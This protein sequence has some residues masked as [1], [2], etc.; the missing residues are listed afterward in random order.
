MAIFKNGSL[1]SEIV[2]KLSGQI[3][4]RSK[5]APVIYSRTYAKSPHVGRQDIVRQRFSKLEQVWKT[6]PVSFQDSWSTQASQNDLINSVGQIYHESGLNLFCRLN[7]QRVNRGLPILLSPPGSKPDI[8]FINFFFDF[9]P[10]DDIFKLDILSSFPDDTYY[11]IEATSLLSPGIKYATDRL[12]QIA[13]LTSADVPSLNLNDAY[14]AVY[15]IGIEDMPSNAFMWLS[16]RA[17]SESTGYS[18]GRITFNGFQPFPFDPD[19]KNVVKRMEQVGT[20]L[21]LSEQ[22][23]I[24]TFVL[25]LKGL[26]SFGATDIWSQLDYLRFGS[27]NQANHAL[28]EWRMLSGFG[29]NDAIP[30]GAPLFSAGQ[31]FQG[32]TNDAIQE[33]FVPASPPGGLFSIDNCFIGALE[34][35]GALNEHTFGIDDTPNSIMLINGTFNDTGA[36]NSVSGN[37]SGIPFGPGWRS[38]RRFQPTH[39]DA[40]IDTTNVF[41]FP[42]SS[43][44]LSIFN[45]YSSGLNAAG[46]LSPSPNS[47]VGGFFAGADFSADINQ[48]ID[49]YNQFMVDFNA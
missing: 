33:S 22:M 1:V 4:S 30:I 3:Y 37:T 15:G 19:A 6:L 29:A 35:G 31:G 12:Q 36:L 14:K 40:F 13:L 32:G 8:N 21:S 26:G 48:F 23:A 47:I 49:S 17:V 18:T 44:G 42:V 20:S 25:N 24:N 45:V 43:S 28:V 11:I 34:F 41:T 9:S 2:G 27:L 39:F 38:V 5:S 7:Y 10:D 46:T 16:I